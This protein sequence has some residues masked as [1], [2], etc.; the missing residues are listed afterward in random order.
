MTK[1][2]KLI[3]QNR[4]EA[5]PLVAKLLHDFT[6]YQTK[7]LDSF[8]PCATGRADFID[9]FWMSLGWDVW[10]IEQNNS[11]KQ[12]VRIEERQDSESGRKRP[13]YCFYAAPEFRD[14]KFLVEAKRPS[15]RLRDVDPLLQ[16][17][18]ALG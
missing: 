5:F 12:E 18:L 11:Y 10:H 7:Y 8:L 14:Q 4:D 17:D 1:I 2:N 3:G 13:D 9:K 16:T 6:Q 15:V